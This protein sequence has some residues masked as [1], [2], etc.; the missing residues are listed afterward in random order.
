MLPMA[1]SLAVAALAIA[2][3]FVEAGKRAGVEWASARFHP[4]RLPPTK[5]GA[6]QSQSVESG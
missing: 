1:L 4:L 2:Q 3:E 5:S 6:D